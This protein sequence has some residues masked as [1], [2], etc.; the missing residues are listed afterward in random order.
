MACVRSRRLVSC[1]EPRQRREVII[2]TDDDRRRFLGR[3]ADLPER[4]RVE[5]HALVLM[6]NP[7]HVLMRPQDL[8]LSR[9]VQWPHYPP[10]LRSNYG[11]STFAEEARN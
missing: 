8:N 4:L 11:Q 9:A 6:G 2:G 5:I 1:R 7:C 3:L 10:R